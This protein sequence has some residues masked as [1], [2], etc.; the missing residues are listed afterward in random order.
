MGGPIRRGGEDRS[1]G[2]D[3]EETYRRL[4][5][6]VLGYFLACA[7][8]DPEDL[9]G[10]VFVG[11]ARGLHRFHGDEDALRRWVLTIAHRR[12]ADDRRRRAVQQSGRA[13]L[14][15]RTVCDPPTEPDIDLV[16]ALEEL[17]PLQRE[18]VVLRFV[19]DLP[20]RDVA[21]VLQRRIS[22]VNA[23]Q[24]RA[25]EQLARRLTPG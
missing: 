1:R 22:A 6:S 20:I 23:L 25:L 21:R 2:A 7:A 15:Q 13:L 8:S 3:L 14:A 9:V 24:S 10:E 16:T 4:A 5:P 11:V 19:A 17:T 18:A 12:L